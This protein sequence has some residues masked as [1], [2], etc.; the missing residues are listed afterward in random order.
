MHSLKW[1]VENSEESIPKCSVSQSVHI[2]SVLHVI[3]SNYKEWNIGFNKGKD[4][5]YRKYLG[6]Y[7]GKGEFRWI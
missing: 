4:S 7:L 6:P 1:K 2:K 5:F 3:A